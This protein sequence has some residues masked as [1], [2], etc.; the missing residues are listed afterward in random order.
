MTEQQPYTVID[1]YPGFELRAYPAHVVAEV[2]VDTAFDDAGNAAFRT[3]AA[4]IFGANTSQRKLAMTAPV[5]QEAATE[6]GEESEALAMTSPVTQQK[7]ATGFTVAFVL[8]ADVTLDTAP[9][10]DDGRVRVLEK[11]AATTAVVSFSGR[12]GSETFARRLME[13]RTALGKAAFTPVGE[14]RYARFDPPITPG[15][16]RHNEVQLDVEAIDGEKS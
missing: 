11:P 12:G 13:L 15:L 3:L 8:P 6:P 7:A 5:T 10:P 9:V 16:F 2:D 1:A 14:P 4:Y